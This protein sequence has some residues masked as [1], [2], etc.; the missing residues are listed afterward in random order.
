MRVGPITFVV[1]V[2]CGGLLT[3]P[4]S[5]SPETCSD[6]I[7]PEIPAGTIRQV[8]AADLIGLRDMGLKSTS[9]DADF[10]AVSPDGSEVAF[11][12]RRAEPD[13]NSYCLGMFVLKLDGTS[14][15][16]LIDEGGDLIRET[17]DLLAAT[18]VPTG[19]TRI[20]MPKWSPDGTRIAFLRRD[21]GVTQVWI[22]R[23]DGGGSHAATHLTSDAED[24]VWAEGGTGLIV[25]WRP[26]LAAAFARIQREGD[27]GYLYD[28]TFMPF[29]APHPFPAAPIGRD[30]LY[31]D[32]DSDSLREATQAESGQLAPA[33]KEAMPGASL[34]AKSKAGLVAWT[35]PSDA[36]NSFS[37]QTLHAILP[38]G[39]AVE[40]DC[41]GDAPIVRMFWADDGRSLFF[42]RQDWHHSRAS[43]SSWRPG[44]TK[45]TLILQTE[46]ALLGCQKWRA[47]L[48]CGREGSLQPRQLVLIDLASGHERVFFDPNPEFR[49]LR[50]GTVQR[51]AWRNSKGSEQ[52]FDMVLPP[53]H[54]PGQKHPLIVVQYE[55]RGFLRGGTDDEYPIQLFAANGFAVLSFQFPPNVGIEQGGKNWDEVNRL[56]HT[57]W[58]LRRNV[59]YVLEKDIGLAA[60]MGVIDTTRMGITGLSEGANM[61]QFAL[62]NSHLFAVAAM[63]GCC[64]E[65]T[66]LLSLS[67][68]AGADYMRH[69]GYPSLTQP[70]ETFWGPYSIRV[71]ARKIRTP[72][73][74]QA[75]D[76]EYLLATETYETLRESGVPVEMYVFPDEFHEKWQPRHRLAIYSRNLDWFRFWLDGYVDPDPS[77]T[78]QY[79][80]WQGLR[81]GARNLTTGD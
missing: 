74:I 21:N 79:K 60:S 52:F 77:K 66:S 1:G 45:E 70:S 81:A 2:L 6:L 18:G 22:A 30:F 4:A 72:L 14:P 59:Q 9:Q 67:G 32:L 73:L 23:S 19:Y 10:L 3:G 49:N 42:L 68:P 8:T 57:N 44:E 24:F 43:I 28:A 76:R 64:E 7:P 54:R 35:A 48:L 26:D 37:K 46:D 25:S 78:I 31:V 40:C 75:A 61:T 51:I 15:P 11:Q 56:D 5:A 16:M 33:M 34:A 13:S 41:R 27:T 47:S 55:T 20:V 12:L 39:K 36:G 63:S 71:N 62:V 38:N 17:Q 58:A 29:A 65:A 50:L 80:R 53:D 69:L